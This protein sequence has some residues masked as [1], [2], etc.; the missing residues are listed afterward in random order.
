MTV[1]EVHQFQFG[2]ARSTPAGMNAE[3]GMHGGTMGLGAEAG[4]FRR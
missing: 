1:V 4:P 2:A 3:L